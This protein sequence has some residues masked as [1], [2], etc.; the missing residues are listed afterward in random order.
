MIYIDTGLLNT[1]RTRIVK[2]FCWYVCELMLIMHAAMYATTIFKAG[3]NRMYVITPAVHTYE[4]HPRA[5]VISLI[6]ELHYRCDV[7][8]NHENYLNCC[9]VKAT[10]LVIFVFYHPCAPDFSIRHKN[11]KSSTLVTLKNH[12]HDDT[13]CAKLGHRT[14]ITWVHIHTR[15]CSHFP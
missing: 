1:S 6:T 12:V 8:I 3:Y 14:K 7:K 5:N 10:S 11:L 15:G 13:F 9:Q 4:C 2:P